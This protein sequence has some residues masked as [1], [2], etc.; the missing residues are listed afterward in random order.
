[1]SRTEPLAADPVATALA[2]MPEA[3]IEDIA[4]RC[5]V[6]VLEVVR[7]LPADS[8]TLVPGAAFLDAA[9]DMADWGS[10]TLVVNTG[11]LILEVKGPFPDIRTGSGYHNLKGSPIGGHLR[12][13]SV[14][15][16]A[17]VTRPLFGMAT[18]SV[19]ADTA[20][21]GCLFKVYLGRTPD[22]ALDPAQVERFARLRAR[23]ASAG[24][25]A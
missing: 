19:Q 8:A 7:R 16:L 12:E 20:D 25:A 17:F 15:W 22:R 13:G 11:D 6:P 9:A 5:D 18:R 3:T 1:M 2:D 4:R 23:L 21:G 24:G 10:I 14:A